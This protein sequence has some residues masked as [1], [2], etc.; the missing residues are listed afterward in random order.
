MSIHRPKPNKPDAAPKRDEGGSKTQ[1]VYI[2]GPEDHA[3]DF[4]K[5]FTERF[6]QQVNQIITIQT[7]G[8][9]QKSRVSNPKYFDK[10]GLPEDE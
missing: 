7:A 10:K 5:K 6:E 4:G 8:G 9:I 1:G 3:K 2:H